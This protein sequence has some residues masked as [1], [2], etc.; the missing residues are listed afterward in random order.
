MIT[1]EDKQKMVALCGENRGLFIDFIMKNI[2][3]FDAQAWSIFADIETLLEIKEPEKDY[4]I[5][6]KSGI[7]SIYGDVADKISFRCAYRLE[8]LKLVIKDKFL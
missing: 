8:L 6:V 5:C 7:E 1:W 4:W 3:N 2:I